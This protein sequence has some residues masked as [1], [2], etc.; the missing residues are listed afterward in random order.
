MTKA[1]S[2]LKSLEKKLTETQPRPV[3]I[4]VNWYLSPEPEKPIQERAK[5]AALQSGER[6]TLIEWGE[7]DSIISYTYDPKQ[8]RGWFS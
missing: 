3:A 8:G 7:G 2:K 5:A 6:E 4:A 1:D